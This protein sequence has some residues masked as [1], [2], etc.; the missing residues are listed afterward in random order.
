MVDLNYRVVHHVWFLINSCSSSLIKDLNSLLQLWLNLSIAASK[1]LPSSWSSLPAL[2]FLSCLAYLQ[3]RSPIPHCVCCYHNMWPDLWKP[4][5]IAQFSNSILLH[6]YNLHTQMYVL[7]KFQL[8]I[9]K[10]FAVTAL[11]SRSIGK[12]NY[13]RFLKRM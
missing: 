1:Y 13:R 12:I 9:L 6:F 4:D 8:C 10:A 2:W 11:Q 5:I 7:A 3:I